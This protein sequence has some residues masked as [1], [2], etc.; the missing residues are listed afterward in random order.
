VEEAASTLDR[1][2]QGVAPKGLPP[3]LLVDEVE[4][5]VRRF[6]P[7][8]FERM[9]A[10]LGRHSLVMVLSSARELDRVYKDIGVTS[11]WENLLMLERVGLLELDAAEEVIRWGAALLG[12]GGAQAMRTWAGRHPYFLQLLGY[13][14]VQARRAGEAVA[15]AVE[16]FQEDARPR[17]RRL[18][19][20]L[21][22][23]EQQALRECV[24]GG[25]AVKQPNMRRRGVVTE[26]GQP[27]GEVLS[28]WVREE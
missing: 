14:L 18:W 22:P 11:P 25:I 4:A 17:V 13:R 8:F 21:E 23:R 5:I 7:R 12:E 2:A 19:G 3:L 6:A 24:D 28:A 20:M 16:R 15:E 9:R 10:M 27:F 26:Q 1:W